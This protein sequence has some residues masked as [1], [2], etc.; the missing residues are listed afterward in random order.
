MIPWNLSFYYYDEATQKT[1]VL[2]AKPGEAA[3][4][5]HWHPFLIDFAKHLKEKG[6]FD[7]TTIA[8][9]ERPMEA[10][11]LAIALIKKADPNFK[12][13]LAG[14]YHEELALDL[15]DYSITLHENMDPQ[16]L[17]ARQARGFTTTAYTCC[18][19]IFPNTFTSSGYSEAVW[20]AWNTV[21]RGFDGYLRWAYDCWNKDPNLDTRHGTW[22]AGDTYFVYPDNCSSIRFERLIEGI[23]DVEKIKALKLQLNDNNKIAERERLDNMI[24][25]FHN[26]DIKQDSIPKLVKEAKTLLNSL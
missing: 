3:Y 5:A 6:W 17:A 2:K 4:E 19:E 23:Q 26:K 10:M 18:S 24:Q 11:Q 21:Q 12:I 15:V 13:S 1:E 22:L 8:M 20:L 9:D 16:I 7:K 14:S 25:K